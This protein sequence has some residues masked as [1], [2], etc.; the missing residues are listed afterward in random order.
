MHEESIKKIMRDKFEP[1][2]FESHKYP[3]A[4]GLWPNEQESLLWLALNADPTGN[5]LEIG[6]F[7][8]GSAVLMCL[9]KKFLCAKGSVI[10]VDRTFNGWNNAFNRNVYRVGKF[11]DI[12]IK[13]QC[14]SG[15]LNKY[16]SGSPLSLAF[17]DGWHSFKAAYRDFITVNEWLL[18]GGYVAFHDVAPQP[19]KNGQIDY[20]YQRAKDNYK[21]WT[22]ESL[23]IWDGK[24][25]NIANYHESESK[26]NFMLDEV[27]A[28]I[29]NEFDFELVDIPVLDGS[30]HFDRVTT[31]R[32]GSTSPYHALVA[33]RKPC[34]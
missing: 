25:Q 30:T 22:D 9:A 32:H 16:Y 12:S 2:G 27:V 4:I 10:S 13:I 20:Y 14:D 23:E 19:Y 24:D 5:L 11:D 15:I 33:I 7:C 18:P 3:N 21:E 31:Y 29:I 34:Q 17:I 8:G 26:Q 28:F 1:F 6:S